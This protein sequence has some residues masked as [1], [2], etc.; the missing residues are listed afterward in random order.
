M[1]D[2]KYRYTEHI[3]KD[4]IHLHVNK[5]KVVKKTKCG[6]WVIKIFKCPFSGEW[7]EIG[8]KRFVL[9]GFGKRYCYDTLE[10]A[11][12]SFIKR[13]EYQASYCGSALEIADFILNN[14]DK[15]NNLTQED[16]I[17]SAEHIT[18]RYYV[19]NNND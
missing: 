19:G 12:N 15:I 4:G 17:L 10:L 13:K 5:F 2:F 6:S 16:V 1:S 9:D 18:S 8:K 3:E 14:K 11:M 7:L